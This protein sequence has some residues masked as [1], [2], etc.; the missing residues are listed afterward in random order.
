MANIHQ[1]KQSH[2]GTG[3][4]RYL[5]RQAYAVL[6]ALAAAEQQGYP[7]IV[8]EINHALRLTL[9]VKDLIMPHHG[10]HE[11]EAVAYR[12]T[13]RGKQALR[14]W[15]QRSQRGKPGDLCRECRQRQRHQ[16]PSGRLAAYCLECQREYHRKRYHLRY[17][18]VRQPKKKLCAD[19]GQQPRAQTPKGR[20]YPY[21][22]DCRKARETVIRQ[23]WRER[24][25]K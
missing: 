19:C 3:K 25:K 4:S 23:R 7:F 11:G 18:L 15:L 13:P 9:M 5:S 21:C 16:Q 10:L 14:Q 1:K 8:V 17:G 20:L 24:M 12:I 6:E 2:F 22:V